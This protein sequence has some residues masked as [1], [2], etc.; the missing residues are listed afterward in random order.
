MFLKLFYEG[1]YVRI[2]VMIDVNFSLKRV[3]SLN[4]E[5]KGKKWCFIKYEKVSFSASIAAASAIIMKNVVMVFGHP[6]SYNMVI[7]C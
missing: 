3:V 5:G 1:N 2:R 6:K 7:S 4:V